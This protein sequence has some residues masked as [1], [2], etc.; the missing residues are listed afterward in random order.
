[1]ALPVRLGP[2]G[3]SSVDQPTLSVAAR[4]ALDNAMLL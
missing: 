3:V 2:A 1:V 4:I